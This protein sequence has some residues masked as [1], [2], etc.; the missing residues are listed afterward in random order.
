MSQK[1][2]QNLNLNFETTNILVSEML[3]FSDSQ[4]LQVQ[5]STLFGDVCGLMSEWQQVIFQTL[6]ILNWN[7]IEFLCIKMLNFS[8]F[9][10][11]FATLTHIS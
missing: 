3:M 7:S 10:Y 8:M 6:F 11:S 1:L 9:W 2:S 4:D 5:F